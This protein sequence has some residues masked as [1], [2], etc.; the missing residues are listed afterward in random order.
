MFDK[1]GTMRRLA[2]CI[3]TVVLAVLLG[4]AWG[5]KSR[6]APT[7]GQGAGVDRTVLPI[8]EPTYPAITELDVR[9]ATA[10]PSVPGHRRRREHPT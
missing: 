1:R 3:L 6:P 2:S 10:P 9:K 4:A 7:N 5:C 8:A